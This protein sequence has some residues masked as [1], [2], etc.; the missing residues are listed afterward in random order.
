MP[1]R[2]I[3]LSASS[4]I[5]LPCMTCDRDGFLAIQ[6]LEGIK[7]CIDRAAAL[8]VRRELPAFV[9]GH[10]H[11]AIQLAGLDEQRTAS[12]GIGLS[13]K[14][15]AEGPVGLPL[16]SGAYTLATIQCDLER[17]EAE[18]VITPVGRP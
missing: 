3:R 14:L 9:A 5:K 6:A 17:T 13:V 8:N 11:D 12:V 16:V 7:Q 4:L 15:A 18:P 10:A 1:M 2:C